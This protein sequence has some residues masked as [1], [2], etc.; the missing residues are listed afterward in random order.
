M[1][2]H[3]LY[4]RL[5]AV[6]IT[7]PMSAEKNTKGVWKKTFTFPTAWQKTTSREYD[8]SATGFALVCNAESGCTGI[9]I[10]D[11]E[12]P[13]NKQL[14]RL[15][16][17][18]T[19]VAR[20]KNGFHY[21]FKND[22]RI[23]QTASSTFKLDTR[24]Y[25]GCLFVAPSVAYDDAGNTVAEYKWVKIPPLEAQ[26]VDAALV[27]IPEAVIDFLRALNSS[28]YLK[29]A[30]GAE[31]AQ[32]APAPAPPLRASIGANDN[33]GSTEG[34]E[35][36]GAPRALTSDQE[37]AFKSAAS[38][39]ARIRA[40][41][42]RVGYA[43]SVV[44][45][46]NKDP[47]GGCPALRV[48][49]RHGGN[50]RVCPVTHVEHDSNNYHVSLG[51]DTVLGTGLPVFT[52]FCHSDACIARGHLLLAFVDPASYGALGIDSGLPRRS[53]ARR[54]LF[55]KMQAHVSQ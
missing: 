35:V 15:M 26:G 45:A 30:G 43:E 32:Q 41:T 5:G 19:L 44:V 17:A 29:Q 2:A 11:P 50:E 12:T 10:D 49:F 38:S 9:D 24:N 7:G 23:K 31:P 16:E 14:M 27:A 4:A 22:A 34:L 21:V 53:P 18:C 6:I 39:A 8:K 47:I 54:E 37:A 1:D 46:T 25:G 20:T 33:S 28:R 36:R 40:G 52:V 3:A 55:D 51:V 13:T 48:N 42:D